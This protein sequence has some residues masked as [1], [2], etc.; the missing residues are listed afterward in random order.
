MLSESSPH[1]VCVH[2]II[3]LQEALKLRLVRNILCIICSG[4]VDLAGVSLF[5][6]L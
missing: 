6:G 5:K 3:L 1:V 4:Q 2:K